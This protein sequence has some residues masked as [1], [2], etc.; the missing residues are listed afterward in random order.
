M[1]S[2]DLQDLYHDSKASCKKAGL[3][4]VDTQK[5]TKGYMRNK[6]AQGNFE[7]AD[8]NGTMVVDEIV[9]SRIDSLSIPPAWEQVWISQSPKGHIQAVGLDAKGI[10]QYIY[11]A[12]WSAFRE[13]LKFDRLLYFAQVLPG[14]RKEIRKHLDDAELTRE[15][16]ISA[17]LTLM[18]ELSI[19]IGNESYAEENKTYGLTTLEDRHV[20]VDGGEI[21][22][23][24]VGK[25]HKVHDFHLENKQLAEIVQESKDIPGKHLF[26]YFDA[27]EHRHPLTSTEVNGF[28]KRLT[29]EQFTAKDFRMWAATVH[30]Y[31]LLKVECARGLS[32]AET[33][34]S[35]TKVVADVAE[36]LGNTPA[37]CKA[38][39][40]HAKLQSSF[41]EGK[42]LD[43]IGSLRKARQ[44]MYMSA[45]E[46]EL[47]QLLEVL[48]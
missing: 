16:I 22:L 44:T 43:L 36:K 9:I 25:S 6:N 15:K 11:H 4:Y 40:I 35:L 17:V 5:Q 28:I 31:S 23:H 33:K 29:N 14:L 3:V 42:L 19:R 39:Y 13:A 1:N 26:Q 45:D 30:A 20:L 7:Y 24:F 2:S 18:D 38:Y 27:D 41:E 46:T 32:D 10:K 48:A 12:K 8:M 47:R 37:V 21:T 34:K